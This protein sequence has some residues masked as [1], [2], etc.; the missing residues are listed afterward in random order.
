MDDDLKS[1]CCKGILSIN[2]RQRVE[3][4]RYEKLVQNLL[5]GGYIFICTFFGFERTKGY[6]STH[7]VVVFIEIGDKHFSC[8]YLN[9]SQSS[10]VT[11]LVLLKHRKIY[12]D[13]IMLSI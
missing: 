5:I 3:K 13:E 12:F 1:I 11:F 7:I 10:L 8:T 9:L 2:I 4:I 6:K